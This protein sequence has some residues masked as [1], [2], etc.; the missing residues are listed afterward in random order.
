[1]YGAMGCDLGVGVGLYLELGVRR[2]HEGGHA[3]TTMMAG[4]NKVPE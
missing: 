3:D 4:A 2:V 1:M